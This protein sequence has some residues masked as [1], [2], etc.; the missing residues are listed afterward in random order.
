VKLILPRPVYTSRS[1][2]PLR[3]A[4]PS[5]RT[6]WVYGISTGRSSISSRKGLWFVDADAVGK[7]D[8]AACFQ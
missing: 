1:G 5:G 8:D 3:A 6:P 2:P 4:G 7:E